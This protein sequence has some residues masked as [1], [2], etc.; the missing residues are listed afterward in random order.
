MRVCG[1]EQGGK[2]PKGLVRW[3]SG[4]GRDE[5]GKWWQCSGKLQVQPWGQRTGDLNLSTPSED[6]H[7][8]QSAYKDHCIIWSSLSLF[9][10]MTLTMQSATITAWLPQNLSQKKICIDQKT[11]I[12]K[13]LLALPKPTQFNL[14]QFIIVSL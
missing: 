11:G 1:H 13:P 3:E 4:N 14:I 2:R 10:S 9:S 7:P 8:L 5:R 6:S 12:P